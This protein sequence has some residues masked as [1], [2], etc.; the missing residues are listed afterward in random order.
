MTYADA[1]GPFDGGYDYTCGP[2][3]G[4]LALPSVLRDRQTRLPRR[5]RTPA[6]PRVPPGL[7]PPPAPGA[8]FLC[9]LH[10]SM[11][12]AWAAAWARLLKSGGE[13]VTLMFPLPAAPGAPAP[14]AGAGADA[15][16][17]AGPAPGA[18]PGQEHHGD[19][20]AAGAAGGP[21]SGGGGG[22]EQ[23][24]PW[25]LT[26]ELYSELLLPSGVLMPRLAQ[27]VGSDCL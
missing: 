22:P 27:A 11:R 19:A 1:D 26:R 20:A 2:C 7:T 25:P 17:G 14:A 21:G 24:P 10:P 8:R 6:R 4:P 16:A 13:L 5:R 18:A 9:A 3:A 12:P 23:G 15:A